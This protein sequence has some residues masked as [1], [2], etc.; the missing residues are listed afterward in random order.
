[1]GVQTAGPGS[2]GCGLVGSVAVPDGEPQRGPSWPAPQPAPAATLLEQPCPGV[3]IGGKGMPLDFTKRSQQ[4]R[5]GV[6]ISALSGNQRASTPDHG[7]LWRYGSMLRTAS[8]SATVGRSDSATKSTISSS[9]ASA[10]L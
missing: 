2:V 9:G 7:K 3:S 10:F 8:H 1:V 6:A 5:A 4:V